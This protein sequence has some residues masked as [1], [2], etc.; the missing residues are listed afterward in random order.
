MRL[1]LA[2][3]LLVMGL[4][5]SSMAPANAIF[6]L[7][8]CEKVKKQV[9]SLQKEIN[10][11]STFWDSYTGKYIPD[12]LIPKLLKFEDKST[13]PIVMLT[14]LAYNNPKCFTR[15]Q[16]E[17]IEGRKQR[18]YS[19]ETLVYRSKEAILKKTKKCNGI[20]QKI[21]PTDD[22]VIKW[23]YKIEKVYLINNIYDQ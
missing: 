9:E 10:A 21:S 2:S 6:G 7:S 15:T 23:K 19:F 12:S 13:D 4:L 20:W 14:K 18:E 8:K 17:E 5:A 16:N 1:K 22:C 11:N 3:S